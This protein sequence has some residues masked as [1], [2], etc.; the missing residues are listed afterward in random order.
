[1]QSTTIGTASRALTSALLGTALAAAVSLPAL[2]AD[3]TQQRLENANAEPQN[4][5]TVFQNYS[6]HGFSG[7]T[8]ITPDNVADLGVAF[9]VP[10]T[11]ALIGTDGSLNLENRPLVDD[12]I[13]YV[14]DAWGG[15]Y[16]VDV[17]SG[18]LGDVVWF[19]D[20]A[21]SKDE[22]P[23]SRG[24]AMWGNAVWK[25]LV[26]GRVVAV[27][28]DTGEFLIDAQI[29]RVDHPQSS[30]LNIPAEGFTA[31]PLAVEGR[32]LV[33]QS[34]GDRATRG[35]LAAVD[36]ETGEEMWRWYAV[37][38]PGEPG[39]ETWADDHNAWKTGGGGM[40]TTGSY[41]PEQRVT[42][43]GTGQPVP[44]FDP[45]FRP[46]DNLY[47]NTAVAINIDDGSLQW[48]FQY[49]PNESWDYDEQGAHILI[50]IGGEKTVQHF[51]RNGF[52]YRID[53]TDGTYLDSGQYVD[54]IT[55]TA[56][57]D[58]KTGKPVEYDP[59]KLLQTYI[60]A[61]RSHRGDDPKTACP[62]LIGGI[63]W[64]PVGFNPNT[65]IAYGAGSDGCFT[66]QIGQGAITLG[67]D[68]GINAEEGGGNNGRDGSSSYGPLYGGLWA[69]DAATG[70]QVTKFRYSHENLSGA[71]PTAGGLVFTAWNDGW[72]TAHDESSLQTLWR[73]NTGSPIKAAPISYAVASKQYVAIVAG[74]RKAY[75][76]DNFP[77][78]ANMNPG[79]FLIVFSL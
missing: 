73:F 18:V 35:W 60:P 57:L 10:L 52:Y 34:W 2:S 48:H 59:N 19:A 70:R 54:Q 51:G 75:H 5:L 7:L 43:W 6:S 64:Q 69:M 53:R 47:S 40:W 61:T 4:W 13:L 67:P 11:S 66:M 79:G 78:I 38:G 71:L 42:I 17:S 31:A 14:D 68:G 12:G 77:D 9:I 63:R 25:D 41:D 44:M 39:H 23:R 26:D 29:A 45:E 36:A 50:D 46:G 33:G 72:V 20:S 27:D 16:K 21:M 3:V 37:P 24:L 56:G 8:Q 49:T 65:G 1:M 28:R 22:N 58:P 74:G 15:I 55:W 76:S 32:I 62:T 30:G